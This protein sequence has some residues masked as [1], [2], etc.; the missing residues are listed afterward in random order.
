VLPLTL[1][2][3][4]EHVYDGL[5][6]GVH[7]Y[8]HAYVLGEHTCSYRFLPLLFLLSACLLACLLACLWLYIYWIFLPAAVRYR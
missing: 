7:V 4:F 6:G 2:R 8:A 5:S 3:S 1:A